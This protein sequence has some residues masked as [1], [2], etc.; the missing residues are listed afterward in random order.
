V[1]GKKDAAN[2]PVKAG[3]VKRLRARLNRGDSWLSYDLANLAPGGKIDEEALEDLEAE[4]V[5]A[6]VGMEASVRIIDSLKKDLARKE[7]R[8]AADASGIDP[9]APGRGIALVT[10]YPFDTYER[11]PERFVVH[12]DEL[13]SPDVASGQLGPQGIGDPFRLPEVPDRDVLAVAQPQLEAAG[14]EQ[15]SE[16]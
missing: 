6:D 13:T 16:R 2:E 7:L 4:L 14:A 11:G 12:A 1:F 3:F 5:M 8:D 15:P 10:C 9:G